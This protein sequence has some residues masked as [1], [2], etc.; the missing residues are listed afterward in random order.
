MFQAIVLPLIR[1]RDLIEV[2][3]QRHVELFV[4]TYLNADHLFFLDARKLKGSEDEGEA[5]ASSEVDPADLDSQLV[6]SLLPDV[7]SSLTPAGADELTLFS[8][9][10]SSY[11]AHLLFSI[12]AREAA[13]PGIPQTPQKGL[14]GKDSTYQR[15]YA[16]FTMVVTRSQH[17][18]A[19][20]VSAL[21]LPAR[22]ST[23]METIEQADLFLALSRNNKLVALHLHELEVIFKA[24]YPSAVLRR[25]LLGSLNLTKL[26]LKLPQTTPSSLFRGIE[27]RCLRW[28]ETNLP[29]HIILAFLQIHNFVPSLALGPCGKRLND[30]DI[31][32]VIAHVAPI[33]QKLKLVETP[34]S[35]TVKIHRYPWSDPVQWGVDL[36]RLPFLEEL[37]LFTAGTVAIPIGDGDAERGIVFTWVTELLEPVEDWSTV[38]SLHPALLNILIQYGSGAQGGF[39]SYWRKAVSHWYRWKGFATPLSDTLIM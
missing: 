29:H 25:C 17:E 8:F 39:V 14:H 24:A 38:T 11:S 36:R 4:P 34:P 37:L 23:R 32:R 9:C 12:P 6:F 16:S 22:D 7:A 1:L 35:E 18:R 13:V 19:L 21:A 28:F 15:C 31:L 26:T 5:D 3:Q 2:L 27:L 20:F 33:L 30:H 10:S